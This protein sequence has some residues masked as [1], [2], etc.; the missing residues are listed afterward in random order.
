ML[1]A[2]LL[3]AALAAGATALPTAAAC[4]H[5]LYGEDTVG[6]CWYMWRGNLVFTGLENQAVEEAH[7]R[8]GAGGLSAGAD[9]APCTP[10]IV[11]WGSCVLP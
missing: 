2:L 6:P 7:V 4:C 8:C 5:L 9:H 11:A 10:Y 3:C 1:K